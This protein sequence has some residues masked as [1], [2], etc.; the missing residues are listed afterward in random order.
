MVEGELLAQLL[1][2]G[3]GG[4]QLLAGLA[5]GLAEAVAA[6]HEVHVCHDVGGGPPEPLRVQ[7]RG[8]HTNEEDDGLQGAKPAVDISGAWWL[9]LL[10]PIL[11]S[12]DANWFLLTKALCGPPRHSHSSLSGA[13]P[14]GTVWRNGFGL[15]PAPV[16]KWEAYLGL[17]FV[18]EQLTGM[19]HGKQSQVEEGTS[20]AS[21]EVVGE[22][23]ALDE[24]EGVAREVAAHHK[25]CRRGEQVGPGASP[26]PLGL[27]ARQR[28]TAVC[29]DFDLP[30]TKV[31]QICIPQEVERQS[32]CSSLMV[33]EGSVA[34]TMVS[35]LGTGA[36]MAAK[37]PSG[38][39]LS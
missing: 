36:S 30:A 27:P 5:G 18:T 29:T 20:R 32:R 24:A 35:W 9:A 25:P 13:K 39:T 15:Q 28:T 16:L 37:P 38:L 7:H 33:S 14:S 10:P 8:S 34:V 31:T 26:L 3:V 21:V 2:A 19:V 1:V 17:L 11:C 4:T 12:L 23:L 22:E 6:L